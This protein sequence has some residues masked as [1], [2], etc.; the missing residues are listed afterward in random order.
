MKFRKAS[1]APVPRT[2]GAEL[3]DP[4]TVRMAALAGVPA[5][6][7]DHGIDPS[8]MLAA[9]DLPQDLFDDLENR[10]SYR[11][12]GLLLQ[13]CAEATGCEHFGLLVGQHA[14]ASTLGTLGEL[15]QRA[16]TVR[17]AIGGVIAHLHLQTRGGIP[18]HTV[19]DSHATFGY[20]LYLRDMPG[21]AQAYDLVLA[22]EFNILRAVCGPRWGPSEVLFSHGMP[23]DVTPYQSLFGCRLE[24]DADRS[25]LVFNK[26]WL[27]QPPMG[28]DPDRH[29]QLL[30]VMLE[31]ERDAPEELLF[32]VRATLRRMVSHGHATEGLLSNLLSVPERSLRRL[33]DHQGTSFRELLEDA[34]YEVARQLLVDTDMSTADIATSLG[35]ADPSAFS[36]AFRRWTGSPPAAWRFKARHPQ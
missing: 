17:A 34:R 1:V 15:A 11:A 18:T 4:G 26:H 9:L 10:M 8:Q 22:F 31:Q 21:T 36:R 13:R 5:V 20:A 24:F 7:R 2:K 27:D 23:K 3:R 19:G 30:L 29:R 32:R 14:T 33:L 25:E 35:Y 28:A 12:G 16:R 6:L